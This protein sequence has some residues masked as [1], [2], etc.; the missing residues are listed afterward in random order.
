MEVVLEMPYPSVRNVYESTGASQPTFLLLIFLPT[1]T[2]TTIANAFV[3]ATAVPCRS[4]DSP[5]QM[6][7]QDAGN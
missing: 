2:T 6:T 5:K 4:Y 1:T 3:L 7:Y